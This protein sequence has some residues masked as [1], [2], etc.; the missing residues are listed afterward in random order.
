LHR[1][2]ECKDRVQEISSKSNF[3][4]SGITV[5]GFR[6]SVGEWYVEEVG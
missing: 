4:A 6:L 1:G 5:Q 2:S 3:Q